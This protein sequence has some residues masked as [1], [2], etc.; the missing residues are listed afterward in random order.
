MAYITITQLSAR[1]GSTI[2]ARLTDRVAGTTAD[3]VVAQQV[4]DEAEAEA[5]SYLA[6][7]YATPVS[8]AEH[9]E[10]AAVLAARVLDLAEY[11][12]W[13]GS[14]FVSEL[15]DRVQRL[16]DGAIAWLQRVAAGDWP[17]PAT[18]PPAPRVAVTDGPQ[19][20]AT[21]RTFTHDEL[22]GV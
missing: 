14:P 1:L 18:S 19:Y 5:D 4:V 3:A 7:R 9:P 2:Y 22:E 12:A 15:P 11:V 8:L 10:L 16:Y 6:Q 13:K 20:R 17:L 21:P